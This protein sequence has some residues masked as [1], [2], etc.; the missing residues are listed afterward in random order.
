[1]DIFTKPNSICTILLSSFV[2]FLMNGQLKAQNL[3]TDGNFHTISYSGSHQDYKIPSSLSD[4]T[5]EVKFRLLGAD[6]GGAEAASDCRARGGDGAYITATFNVGSGSDKLQPGGTIRFVVGQA[7]ASFDTGSKGIGNGGGG[8]GILY[9][10]NSTP[11]SLGDTPSEDI[12]DANS[13]WILLAVAGGGSGAYRSKNIGICWAAQHGQGG[14]SSTSGGDGSGTGQ[15]GSSGDGGTNGDGCF[16]CNQNGL[17]GG[18]AY[19]DGDAASGGSY[20]AKGGVTGGVTLE[21]GNEFSFGYGAGGYWSNAGSGGGGGYSGGGGG[22]SYTAE[23]GG[24]GGSFVNDGATESTKSSGG[25]SEVSANNGYAQYQIL[26]TGAPVALCE[27]SLSI[28]ITPETEDITISTNQ[29][30]AGSYDIG[31]GVITNRSLDKGDCA[32]G[33]SLGGQTVTLFVRDDDNNVSTCQTYVEI[34]VDNS[35]IVELNPVTGFTSTVSYLGTYQDA[36]VPYEGGN[37]QMSFTLNGGDGG[38]ARMGANACGTCKSDGGSGAKITVNFEIGCGEGQLEPGSLLRFIV[39]ENGRTQTGTEVVCTG[40]ASGGGGGGTALLYKPV[41]CADWV[42]LAVAGGG[43]GAYQ[44]MLTG[45]C[46][47]SSSGR[48]GN[49]DANGDATDGKGDTYPGDGGT[50][51]GGGENNTS[52]DGTYGGGGGGYLTDGADSFCGLNQYYGGGKKG[53]TTGGEGGDKD[54]PSCAVGRDGGFGF[55]GGGLAKD[56]GGGGGGYSGGGGGGSTGGGGGGGSFINVDYALS[57]SIGVEEYSGD[58]DDGYIS[59]FF[60]SSDGFEPVTTAVCV[61]TYTVSIDEDGLGIV[62]AQD[63]GGESYADCGNIPI[64]MEVGTLFGT[65]GNSFSF[66]CDDVGNGVLFLSTYVLDGNEEL[67]GDGCD[68][69]LT[70]VDN[71]FP[72]AVCQDK[73]VYIN[74]SGMTTISAT[75]ID[76]GSSDNC[77]IDSYT[78]DK[79]EFTCDDI[80]TNYVNLTVADDSGNA[81]SCLA[82]VSVVAVSGPDETICCDAPEAVCKNIT[83]ELEAGGTVEISASEIDNGSTAECGIFS[84]QLDVSTFDCTDIGNNIVT[85][86]V[87]DDNGNV[88]NCGAVVTVEEGPGVTAVC[89]DITIQLNAEGE[90][91]INPEDVD[92]G[93]YVGCDG[94]TPILSLN[95]DYFNCNDVGLVNNPVTLTATYEGNSSSCIAIITTEDPE[96]PMAFCKD[97]SVILGSQG[98]YILNDHELDDGSSDNCD[99]TFSLSQNTLSCDDIGTI[100][101]IQT[102]TDAEGNSAT[103]TSMVTVILEE[104]PTANCQDFTLTL[105]AEGS[106]TLSP[107]DIDNGS[108][109]E[110]CGIA[111]MS[112]SETDFTCSDLGTQTVTLNVTGQGGASDQCTASV[113]ITAYSGTS[114]RRWTGAVSSDWEDPDNWKNGCLPAAG[115]DV[116]ISDMSNDPVI[117]SGSNA[118][119]K[120]V[121]TYAGATLTIESGASLTIEGSTDRGLQ[122]WDDVIQNGLLQIDNT[123]GIGL[124]LRDEAVLTNTGTINIGQNS[125]NISRRGI[126]L[127]DDSQLFNDGGT[128]RVDKVTSVEGSLGYGIEVYSDAIMTNQNGGKIYIGQNGGIARIGLITL[129]DGHFINDGAEL[130]IDNT[131][132]ESNGDAIQVRAALT[133]RN[134]GQIFIGQVSNIQRFG[135]YAQGGTVVNDGADI[136]IDRQPTNNTGVYLQSTASF[137]NQ[138]GANLYLGLLLPDGDNLAL[139]NSSTCVFSNLNCSTIVANGRI[140]NSGTFTN[141]ALLKIQSAIYHDNTGTF[142]NTGIIQYG[143]TSITLS[144]VTNEGMIVNPISSECADVSPALDLAAGQP[145]T[146]LDEWFL[147]A[148]LTNKGGDYDQGT[149]AFTITGFAEGNTETL[150]FTATDG[151]CTFDL[152]LALTYDDVTSP[153]ALCQDITV[154]LDQEG[155]VTATAEAVDNGSNDDCGIGTLALSQTNFD[156]THLG[157]NEVTLYVTDVHGNE[158]TCSADITVEDNI[159]PVAI[160]QD[161]TLTLQDIGYATIEANDIDNTSTDNCS[162]EEMSVSKDEFY[163][164]DVG[165]VSVTL[166]LT[167]ESENSSACTATVTVLDETAPEVACKNTTVYLDNNGS[168]S[169][170]PWAVTQSYFDACGIQGSTV[171]QSN[172]DCDDVGDNSITLTVTDINGNSN[173][174]T[175]TV[176]VEDEVAPIAL[177]QDI[178]ILLDENGEGS[179]T[180]EAVDNGSNDACGIVSLALSQTEFTCNFVGL[181]PVTLTVTDAN[182]NTNTCL[183]TVQVEDNIA[184]TALCQ[185]V[186]VQLDENGDGSTSEDAV[187]NG[188]TD[189]CG[190]AGIALS[191][192]YFDCS[193]VGPNTE[194]LYVT[195][196]HGNESTC[197]TTV[198][199]EDN[200]APIALCQNITIQLDE[201]GNSSTTAQVIDNGSN[202]ACGIASLALSQ[203]DFDCSH[204]GDN[205]VTLTATDVNDNNASC[206]ATVTV[207]DNVAPIALCQ[208]ATIQLDEAG[209]VTLAAESIDNGSNDACGIASLVV[210]PNSFDC[211]HIGDN[212]VILTVT[213]NNGN[214]ST[215]SATATVEDNVAPAISQCEGLFAIFN[216]EEEIVASSVIDFSATDACGLQSTAYSPA[217]ITCDQLGQNVE[218]LVTV[219]DVNGNSSECLAVVKTDGLPCGWM[220]FGDDGIDCE[221]SNEVDYNASTE[222]FTLT[223]N[224]CATTNF[225]QDDAAYVQTELCGDGEIIAHVTDINPLGQGWA[226]ITMR[227]SEAPGA[228][229]VELLSN[230]GNMLRRAV[231]TTTNGYAYPAQFFRPQATW[232]KLVRSGNLFIGYA[233]FDGI[234]WQNVLF[235]NIPMNECI[236]AGLMV[237]NYNGSTVVSGTFDNVEVNGS[238]SMNLQL[239]ENEGEVVAQ[240]IALY[241]NPTK[242]QIFI[243]LN[244]FQGQ[245]IELT[246]FNQQGQMISSHHIK[247]VG[248][249]P[250][251][252]NVNEMTTGSYYIQISTDKR[253]IVKRFSILK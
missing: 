12:D 111:E 121:R 155:G 157:D 217:V 236:Q 72:T 170:D 158:S 143:A 181:N 222:T 200:V 190:I 147:D 182:G 127:S 2:I 104:T 145:Y 225:S 21:S 196:V 31:D 180:P 8:T 220:D 84:T 149:N 61:S 159:S 41:G 165:T 98:T 78:L 101:V 35:G 3:Q 126:D 210:A 205:T 51:G 75:D 59:Y 119:A 138:N 62:Y 156:C 184:P 114:N 58:P 16:G 105:D 183:A 130:H 208:N 169:I 144:E 112:L 202:D 148:D 167:D 13:Q 154:L 192:I 134:G 237:T 240:D 234:N 245:E 232:L 77:G 36:L 216:G 97:R 189:A 253:E 247:E 131:G 103:C 201:N 95:T 214:V 83:V 82:V 79:T 218:V 242:D 204:V 76:D 191:Q 28:T 99:L 231:R 132:T 249:S 57:Y 166:T 52:L 109:Q 92:G 25:T 246:I 128:I 226:G 91:F 20:A 102:V 33:L 14:R 141:E 45:A 34:S 44:G 27:E 207:V 139:N 42:V 229:K 56:A 48:N 49:T 129:I 32:S 238:G 219:T 213:D 64:T 37:S 23:R 26:Q 212:A 235:A 206:T 251:E 7:G 176:T 29:I 187:D 67:G 11:S 15:G 89:Q 24:G 63:I 22:G 215:C 162:I 68:V 137:T 203:T 18:G 39:G 177:C 1:M 227:E 146:V 93:S 135:I 233:S 107:S 43:G 243:D 153:S 195:D 173:S 199:V 100:Q 172:F 46:V 94:G 123:G 19:G 113:T 150:Y 73:T 106:A 193:E 110:V 197:T 151:S 244:S 47:D 252:L 228:K 17:A 117:Y 211:S 55:G 80:G 164:S 209:L 198:F 115:D 10:A 179:A 74:S 60:K 133:N 188:S 122:A 223:S 88:G 142:T 5:Y 250:E 30:D 168:A 96:I 125:G 136:Y 163:C 194:T 9:T 241:P 50:D 224:G 87:T 69:M 116:F 66:D 161:I 90:Y 38:W 171:S 221:D 81:S 108:Y 186:T 248:S 40:G 71:I 140:V 70:I 6:G 185:N 152:S 53:G 174:C 239:P 85:L 4:G 118:F 120:S 54:G 86:V 175:A 230:L 124:Q 160:C 65:F 178:T